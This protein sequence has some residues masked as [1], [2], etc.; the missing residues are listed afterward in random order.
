MKNK[1]MLLVFIALAMQ[2]MQ[3][4]DKEIDTQQSSIQK[5]LKLDY[6][7][8]VHWL[9]IAAIP[10]ANDMQKLL[11]AIDTQFTLLG[12]T[13]DEQNKK[14]SYA[15]IFNAQHKDTGNTV[16]HAAYYAQ[17][18]MQFMHDLIEYGANIFLEN[19]E[20]QTGA[21]LLEQLKID[22]VVQWLHEDIISWIEN[23]KLIY[24]AII[25]KLRDYNLPD[26]QL[27]VEIMLNTPGKNGAYALD[28][29]YQKNRCPKLIEMLKKYGAKECL[30]EDIPWPTGSKLE[31]TEETIS[32]E[33]ILPQEQ[34]PLKKKDKIKKTV[35]INTNNNIYFYES[36]RAMMQH[37]LTNVIEKNKLETNNEQ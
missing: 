23:P 35:T 21:A 36:I 24:T 29:A 11:P 10:D 34:M 30:V 28:V 37:V 8:F 18:D 12:G 27:F 26:T 15:E 6:H 19:S 20:G 3:S 31:T 13:I 5:Q 17:K 1:I 22:Y 25:Q 33:N 2:S 9:H 4:M 32:I 16:L 14:D 7:A